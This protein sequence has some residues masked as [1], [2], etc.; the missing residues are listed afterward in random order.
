M[1]YAGVNRRM[2]IGA[3]LVP[4]DGV[5]FRVWAPHRRTVEVVIEDRAQPQIFE[6]QVESDGYFSGLCRHAGAGTRY[7]FRLDG[8]DNLYPDPA[9][10]FQPEG[11]HGPSQVVDPQS[12]K[13]TDDDWPG[14]GIRGQVIYELHLGT[15]TGEGTVVA[16]MTELQELFDLGVTIIELMPI[17]EFPGKFG[18]GY[19]GVNL[20]APAR[21]YGTPDDLRRFVDCAH[22]I[23]LGVI[24]DVVYNHFGPDG[25]YLSEFSPDYFTQ[26]HTTGWGAAIN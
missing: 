13:W 3:E 15:F 22:K 12:F 9:S 4:E 14:V 17:A 7:R 2:Q 26:K 11:P 18:W 24:L 5:H 10:R 25:N 1:K 23:G 6:L 19:D 21:I 20:F 16:S 8:G